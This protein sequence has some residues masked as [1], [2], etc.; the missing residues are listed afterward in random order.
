MGGAK[1]VHEAGAAVIDRYTTACQ[2]GGAAR[3]VIPPR[4]IDLAKIP[5]RPHHFVRLN[6]EFQADLRWWHVFADH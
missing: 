1:E 5:K 3:E 4:M 2:P 6:M